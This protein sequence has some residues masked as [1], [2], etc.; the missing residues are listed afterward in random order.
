MYYWGGGDPQ[1]PYSCGCYVSQPCYKYPKFKC[2]CDA[3]DLNWREDGG[4][5]TDKSTL[6]VTQVR[7]GDTGSNNK[8]DGRLLL[9]ELICTGEI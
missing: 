2:N 1:V 9:K 4:Y 5:L 6:P 8:D 7:L 3:N